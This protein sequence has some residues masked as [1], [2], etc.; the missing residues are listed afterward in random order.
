MNLSKLIPYQNKNYLQDKAN[1]ILYINKILNPFVELDKIIE[2]YKNIKVVQLNQDSKTILKKNK[3]IIIINDKLEYREYR[4]QLAEE[5][6]HALLHMG[7]QFFY[8]NEITLNKQENQAKQM[9]AYLLCPISMIKEVGMDADNYALIE[10]LADIF[11]VTYEFMH[12]RLSLIWGQ[13]VDLVAYNKG[14]AYA[15]F[16]YDNIFLP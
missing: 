3:A 13:D 9:A 14:Q 16:D 2:K 4:E 5:F 7:N 8:D 6:C 12:Y 11:K 15:Y 10:E 1:S